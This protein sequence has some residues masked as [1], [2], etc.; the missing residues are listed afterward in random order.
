MIDAV[1]RLLRPANAGKPMRAPL[2]DSD[3]VMLSATHL[4]LRRVPPRIHPKHLCRYHPRLA[5]RLAECWGD[6]GRVG[7]FMDDLLTDRRG[8]RKGLSTRVKTELLCLERFH[9]QHTTPRAI[10]N[11]G[12]GLAQPLRAARP[13]PAGCVAPLARPD[14]RV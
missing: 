7:Q 5:N 1:M 12:R 10:L 14:E 4:W 8:G 9:S 11:R 13:A 2:T 3:R 6:R